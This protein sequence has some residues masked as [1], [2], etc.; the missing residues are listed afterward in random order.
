MTKEVC[1]VLPALNEEEHIGRVID[2]IPSEE[3]RRRGYK[4]RILVVD[5]GSE[6]R[7]GEIA[8][9]KG[10]EVIEETTRGKGMA[11]RAAFNSLS[12]DFVFILD[13]DYTYPATHILEMLD[14]L[15]DGYDVVIGSR[16]KGHMPKGAMSKLNLVGNHLLAFIAN[17]LYGTRISDPC[18]GFWGLRQETIKDMELNATGFE[19]EA[20]I[21]TEISKNGYRITEIPIQYR[22]RTSPPKLNSLRDG[23]RI[24]KFLLR[25]R[26]LPK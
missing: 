15:E 2:E 16:L 14:K 9:G 17:T 25:K 18:T 7:T 24:S 23:L 6:D 20:D 22:R 1:I 26:F 3:M 21:L 5:N 19:I 4:A 10:V 8:S 11:I 12:G 13:A